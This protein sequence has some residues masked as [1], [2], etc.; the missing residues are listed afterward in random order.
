MS[1]SEH[2]IARLRR[3]LEQCKGIQAAMFE[4]SPDGLAILG[5]DGLVL[6]CNRAW[7]RVMDLKR[8]DFVGKTDHEMYRTTG[9]QGPYLRTDI[10]SADF[11]RAI[12]MNIKGDTVLM[13]AHPHRD[14]HGVVQHVILNARNLTHLNHLKKQIEH[15]GKGEYARIEDLKIG[16]V[17]SALRSAGLA[18]IVVANSAFR[19]VV[20]LAA[21]VAPLSA[22]A[23]L[24]GETG[25][26]KGIIAKLIHRLSPRAV[27]PFVELNC[28]AIPDGLVESELFGYQPGAF[29][30]SGRSGKKG[31][32]ELAEGG[33]LFLDEVS[34]LPAASQVKLLKF[35]DDKVIFPLGGIAAKRVDVRILAAT[36]S[37]LRALVG[38]GKFRQDLLYRLEV[39]PITIPPLRQRREEI[40]PLIECFLEQF[41]REFG[42]HRTISEEVFRALFVYDYPGNVRELRNLVARMVI[43]AERSQIGVEDLPRGLRKGTFAVIEA[44]S[45]EPGETAPEPAGLRESLE[46][47]ER[48]ILERYA[49][50]CRSAHHIARQIGLHHTSV[51]RKLRKYNIVFPQSS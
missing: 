27:R 37:D 24:Y 23:L 48:R 18:E 45:I 11:S 51:I 10:A 47:T 15:D 19:N 42:E 4:S 25:T 7:E 12:L 26:G 43:S 16:H 50:T 20:L 32:I 29:T 6:D 44:Q 46:H 33:T 35:L 21:Q 3:E 17:Q 40:R 39:V 49:R 22:S 34:E 13:T 38:Q 31:Q 8:A 41:N 5:T 9:Y 28:G 1:S 2:E 14:L 30:D 36:N